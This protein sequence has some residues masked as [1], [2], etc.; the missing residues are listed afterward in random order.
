MSINISRNDAKPSQK[1]NH[2]SLRVSNE[3]LE[4]IEAE[5][6][7][8]NMNRSEYLLFRGTIN[9]RTLRRLKQER[10]SQDEY[11]ELTLIRR[12]YIAQGNNLN[13]IARGVNLANQEGRAIEID[14][15]A[16][17]EIAAANQLIAKRIQKL[18]AKS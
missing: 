1:T 12:E 10:L 18:G 2:I 14:S 16:L 6:R 9:D 3:Q 7:A 4:I 8:V 11:A 17:Q 13:Q 5:C 15:K